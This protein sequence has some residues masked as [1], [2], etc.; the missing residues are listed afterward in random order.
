MESNCFQELLNCIKLLEQKTI[1]FPDV[2]KQRKYRL[3]CISNKNEKFELMSLRATNNN[4]STVG[5]YYPLD[6]AKF[7]EVLELA[8]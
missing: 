1:Q 4:T 2:G 7:I 6:S 8:L 5:H 3:Y